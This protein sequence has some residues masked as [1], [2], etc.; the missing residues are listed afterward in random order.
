MTT[1]TTLT[2]IPTTSAGGNIVSN[3]VPAANYYGGQGYIQTFTYTLD[4]FQGNISVQATQNNTLDT[5]PWFEIHNVMANTATTSTMANS[6]VGNFSWL[7]AVVTDF[8]AGNITITV[9][10]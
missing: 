8:T 2:L 3:G 6:I 10:Y 4:G 1:Y 5:V 7:R 9:A